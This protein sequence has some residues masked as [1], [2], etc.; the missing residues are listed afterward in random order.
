MPPHFGEAP[1]LT[2]FQALTC[3]S[4]AQVKALI[5][6]VFGTLVDWRTGVAAEAGRM[7]GAKGIAIDPFDFADQWR[8]EYQPAMR[9]IREGAR[10]YVPLDILHREN[11]DIVL[12][13]N[14]ISARFD[15]AE[16]ET[17]NHAWEKLPAWPDVPD[18][19]AALKERFITAPCSNGSIAMMVRLARFAGLS[20]DAILG[21]DIARDYKPKP[22]TYLASVAALGLAPDAVMMVAAHNDDLQAAQDCGLKTAFIARP[23]EYG[24][25]AN[26]EIT[27]TGDWNC[28]ATDLGYLADI[29]MA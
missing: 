10:G 1:S 29:L 2:A 23:H 15:A 24:P 20:W 11:L 18:A 16:R 25:D 6:D 17:L 28:A 21:A 27:P 8:G 5:F 12:E 14:A 13:K 19:L 7:F 3:L 9:R 4:M 22:Q 26:V